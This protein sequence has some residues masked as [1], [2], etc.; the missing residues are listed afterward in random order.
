[1]SVGEIGWFS[2]RIEQV[3]PGDQP[4]N[5]EGQEFVAQRTAKPHHVFQLW[6]PHVIAESVNSKQRQEV[7]CGDDIVRSIYLLAVHILCM[8]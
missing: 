1:M 7:A 2:E 4:G 3:I 8:S 5:M 6:Q